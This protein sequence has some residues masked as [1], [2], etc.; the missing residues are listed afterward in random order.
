MTRCA[1][2]SVVAAWVAITGC[3]GI[4]ADHGSH[5]ARPRRTGTARAVDAVDVASA[6]AD[7]P[8]ARLTRA[9]G[10]I[11][12]S[13]GPLEEGAG[14][15]T[16]DA[17]VVPDEGV[18]ELRLRQGGVVVLFGGSEAY[19]GDG[20]SQVVL[21]RG[22][23][24]AQV[25]PI[26]AGSQPPLRVST[27][28]ASI[29]LAFG[30]DFFLAVHPTAGVWVAALSGTSTVATGEVD[31]RRRLR[32]V[33]LSSG[34]AMS[35]GA[36]LSEPTFGP[37]HLDQARVTAR[38]AL[39]ETSGLEVIRAP[40]DLSDIARR[41]DESLLWLETETRRGLELTA[42]H[43]DAARMG[44]AEEALRLERQLQGHAQQLHALRQ[45]ATA[46]WER[47]EAG[48][49]ELGRASGMSNVVRARRDRIVSLLG[50]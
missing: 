23:L 7:E 22:E 35:M 9:E 39:S 45:V 28:T 19:L 32:V 24:H 50:I 21:L 2:I 25:P 18:A 1:V 5:G 31:G 8:P 48:A 27:P 14:L 20:P 49:L 26:S 41:L 42:Q 29:E 46:R 4:E 38:A 6:P 33:E 13:R 37:T 36:R 10:E 44:R 11:F 43:R 12:R 47:L 17:L 16:G 3:S 15:E 30:G 40:R 34:R